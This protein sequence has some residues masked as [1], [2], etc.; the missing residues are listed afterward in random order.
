MKSNINIP[1]GESR[2]AGFNSAV[3]TGEFRPPRK[4]EWYASGA[5]VEAYMAP[6]DL[7]TSYWIC[8]PA[9]YKP[10][11]RTLELAMKLGEQQ[12]PIHHAH[13]TI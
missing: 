4:G 11:R 6:N 13:G 12:P 1:Y 3:T 7:T 8:V 9:P 10:K 5:V 2:P